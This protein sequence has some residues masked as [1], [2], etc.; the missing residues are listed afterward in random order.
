MAAARIP[1]ECAASLARLRAMGRRLTR[2]REA[3]VRALAGL[4]CAADAAAVHRRARRYHPRLAL[5]TVY[6]TLQALAGAGVARVVHIGDGRTRYEL[7]GH[8]HHLICILCG[9]VERLDACPV[10]RA[11]RLAAGRGFVVQEH[12]LDLFGRCARCLRPA[13]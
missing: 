7:A 11:H 3:V 9:R 2:Q 8:H 5:A 4:G 1:V 6:R 13:R 10:R 12:R